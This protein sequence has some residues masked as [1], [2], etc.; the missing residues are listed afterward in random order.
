MA[1]SR[2]IRVLI[3]EDHE[4]VAANI[5]DHLEAQ[6]HAVDYAADGL[7]GIHLLATNE[8][9]A[10][11]LDLG[12]PGMDG[13]SVC[14][15]LRQDL[16]LTTPVLMLTA[17]DTLP[18]KLVGFEAGTDDYL[19]KPFALQ[20]LDARLQ[21]LLRRGRGTPGPLR[22]ADLELD[23]T[24]LE[25]RRAGR[26]LDL[27]PTCFTILKALVEA[28]PG[29]VRRTRLEELLWGGE[30][31]DSDALRSHIY[32]L[33]CAVDRPFDRPLIHTVHGVGYRLEAPEEVW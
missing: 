33:R 4:D 31:P 8:Y 22:V 1:W 3:V 26:R 24:R 20:E 11:V 13:L 19:V 17:R 12:L 29:V 32:S 7:G 30:P 25:A 10:V 28:S 18:D 14:R 2:S 9:D 16:R 27:N 5:G 21:A 15:R 6:G 23:P